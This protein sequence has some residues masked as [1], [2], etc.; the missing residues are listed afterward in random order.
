[1]IKFQD[2]L[3]LFIVFSHNDKYIFHLQSNFTW[4][5]IENYILL[6]YFKA[7]AMIRYFECV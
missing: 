5:H 6:V 3:I 7:D 4:Y 1:M 2:K